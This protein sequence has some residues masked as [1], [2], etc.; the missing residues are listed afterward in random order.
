M[1]PSA[2]VDPVSQAV[3]AAY[4]DYL[5]LELRLSP[6][7]ISAYMAE[8]VHFFSYCSGKSLSA[9][10]VDS[11]VVIG[12]LSQRNPAAA[13]KGTTAKILSSLRSLFR[14]LITEEYRTDNPMELIESPQP[15]RK[16]PGVLSE[17]E[18]DTF[19][20]AIPDNTAIG[21]RDKAIF[22]LIYS[23]GLRVSEAAGLR[24]GNLYLDQRLI[25][26][27]G[28]RDKERIL[29]LGKQ[30]LL[31]LQRYLTEAR[32]ALSHTAVLTDAL[33]LARG[34]RPISRKT[35][36]SRLQHYEM[37]SG[38]SLKVH[39]LR[40][41]YA[42]HLLRGGADLRSVQKL[43]GHADIGTT[44]IYTHVNHRDLQENFEKFHPD[45]GNRSRH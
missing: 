19:L 23:C 9:A 28:K 45:A 44:Q 29:P 34:G 12:Y 10:V 39:T 8:A 32:L 11:I 1:A 16:L 13:E 36:W 21:L 7:T 30:A 26:V 18:V 37:L 15:D 27:R 6:L 5:A 14:F 20:A 17:S 43:L 3:L 41:C 35:V 24:V 33:F 38:I 42:T 40:H 22:E 2:K 31:L 25:R 4:R